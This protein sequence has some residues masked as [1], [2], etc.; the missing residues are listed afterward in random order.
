MANIDGPKYTGTLLIDLSDVKDDLVDLPPNALKGARTEKDGLPVVLGELAAAMPNHGDEAEIHPSIYQRVLTDTAIIAKLRAHE[1]A[2][3]KALEV[4]RETRG[5]K[6]NNREDDLSAIAIKVEEKAEKGK[7][8]G[9]RAIF[10]KTIAYKSQHADKALET[11]RKNE[12]AKAEAAKKEQAPQ[13][14]GG[15]APPVP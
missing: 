13:G 11:R 5:K 10:E 14:D 6:E 9:L 12:Q 4:V 8:P 2:L 3:E 15:Q 1:A 7:N